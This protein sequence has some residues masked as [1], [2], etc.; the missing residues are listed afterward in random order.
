MVT[1]W[2]RGAYHQLKN[3]NW[4]STYVLLLKPTK[5]KERGFHT[6]YIW[7]FFCGEL[8][9]G[10]DTEFINNGSFIGPRDETPTCEFLLYFGYCNSEI[11]FHENQNTVKIHKLGFALPK[12]F[13][14]KNRRP[15]SVGDRVDAVSIFL[16]EFVCPK[17]FVLPDIFGFI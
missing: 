9:E 12:A 5:S 8:G 3:W 11:I 7:S 1:F 2:I 14:A 15:F 4:R 17:A 10:I 16:S 6:F 13:T